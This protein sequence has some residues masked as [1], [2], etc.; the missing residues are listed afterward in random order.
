MS[1]AIIFI[2][3]ASI[4]NA[5]P[6]YLFNLFAGFSG[7]NPAD[8]LPTATYD[9]NMTTIAAGFFVVWTSDINIAKYN[10]DES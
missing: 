9:V 2:L 8:S 4:F 7:Q 6:Q 10:H 5:L 1:S 3:V